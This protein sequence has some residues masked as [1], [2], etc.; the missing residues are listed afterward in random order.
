MAMPDGSFPVAST[1]T[2]F[3]RR[4]R[5]TRGRAEEAEACLS[6]ALT[7]ARTLNAKA[8]ELQAALDLARLWGERDERRKAHNFLA[9][10][11]GWFSEGFDTKDL[12]DAKRLLDDSA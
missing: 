10:V 2:S 4:C 1:A 6:A 3:A 12:K 7:I 5:R 8:L 11:Y 9:P